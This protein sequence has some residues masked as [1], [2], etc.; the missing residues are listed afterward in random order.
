MFS[1][2]SFSELRLTTWYLH[3]EQ[4]WNGLNQKKLNLKVC[5]NKVFASGGYPTKNI[6]PIYDVG[7]PASRMMTSKC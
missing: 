7:A 6:D 4:V 5:L 3:E 2:M 1:F